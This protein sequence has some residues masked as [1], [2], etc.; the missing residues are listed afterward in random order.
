MVKEPKIVVC[1]SNKG[2]VSKT[3]NTVLLAECAFYKGLRTLVIDMD[4]Q[5]NASSILLGHET[6]A[7]EKE[8][9]EHP[10]ITDEEVRLG[11]YNKRSSIVDIYR[12][13]GVAPYR[14]FFCPED[15]ED[16]TAPCVDIIPCSASGMKWIQETI[17][18]SEKGNPFLDLDGRQLVRGVPT[19]TVIKN[20]YEFC[21][22]PEIAEL[23]D[24]ILID[25]GPGVNTL[26][27]AALNAAT[28][29]IAPY[30]PENLAVLGI[31]PLINQIQHANRNRPA[32]GKPIEF[33]GILPSKVDSKNSVHL[34]IIDSMLSHPT[35]SK[36]H[37][38]EDIYVPSS[39]KILR[40]ASAKRPVKPYSVFKLRP[41]DPL[42][43]RLEHTFDYLLTQIFAE[44]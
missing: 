25:N 39:T 6:V 34:E 11:Y 43:K 40:R 2:G 4:G 30:T 31:G 35:L 16:E 28:H 37:M 3:T 21:R 17:S 10:D 22:S 1:L 20:I 44:D 13:K 26:F 27:S 9:P 12:D 24:M 38:P 41:S 32:G 33:I 36:A 42:R 5:L 8:P 14:T 29:V 19:S 18:S 7:G 23:Y 15:P